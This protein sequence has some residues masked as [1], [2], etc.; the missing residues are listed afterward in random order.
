MQ[1]ARIARL[2]IAVQHDLQLR[3]LLLKR[4]SCLLTLLLLL[5][6][7]LLLLRCQGW[8]SCAY[9]VMQKAVQKCYNFTVL[10][11]IKHHQEV[12]NLHRCTN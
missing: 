1:L 7:L 3:V 2:L 8:E 10:D 9:A 6:Q 5:L 12:H 11:A 4:N